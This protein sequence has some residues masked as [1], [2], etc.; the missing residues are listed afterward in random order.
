MQRLRR[1]SV[2]D[3]QV[4]LKDRLA[5]GLSELFEIQCYG[6]FGLRHSY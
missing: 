2:T 6:T 4:L 3:K 1:D 5:D